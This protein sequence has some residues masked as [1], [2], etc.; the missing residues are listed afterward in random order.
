M[1]TADEISSMFDT[2]SQ[3]LE[4]FLSKISDNMEISEIVETYYQVMNVTSMISMLKQQL[5]SETHSTLL[6]KIDKTEQLVLGKFN[7]H[8]HPKIL[9]NLSNSIQEMTKILQLSAGEKTKEQIENESQMF[10][11]LRKKMSTKEFVEQYDKGL[12]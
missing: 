8:T 12:T 7:T 6:E 5:N 4:N 2:E 3:K 1:S 11:E 10:E 9:E